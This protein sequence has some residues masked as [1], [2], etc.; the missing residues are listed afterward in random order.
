MKHLTSSVIAMLLLLCVASLLLT[1]AGCGGESRPE[2]LQVA[3]IV[4]QEDQFFRL[5]LFGMRDAAERHGIELLEASSARKPDKEIQLVNT[6]IARGV[7]AIV[8]SPLSTRASISALQRACDKGVAV[9]TYNTTVESDLPASYIESDQYDLGASTGKVAREYI[10]MHLDGKAN[11]AIA[12]FLSQAPEQS[13]QRTNG[14]KDQVTTLP[15]VRIV[16]EQDAWLAEQAVKKVGDI[17]TANP[18]LD[19]LW[20]ANEGGT[21]GAV[22]AVRNAGKAGQVLVYGT[23]TSEQLAN[24]LLSEDG[25][26]QAITGQQPFEIGLMAVDAAVRVLKGQPVEKR[27]SL[28]GILL[29]R[30]RPEEVQEFKTRLAELSR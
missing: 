1:L 22:M 26:L 20:A 5:V 14:F 29:S 3:G 30:D 23:D 17:L 16:A 10:E 8:I 7:D 25:V 13:I 24:F 27:V 2:R 21:V 28:S 15:G 6:Y 11:I 12:A 9:I 4:F 19:I 18:D